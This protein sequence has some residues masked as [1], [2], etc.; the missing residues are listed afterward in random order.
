MLFYLNIISTLLALNLVSLNANEISVAQEIL[1]GIERASTPLRSTTLADVSSLPAL[2][3]DYLHDL[4]DALRKVNT[5]ATN[6]QECMIFGLAY[7]YAL[8]LLPERSPNLD[9]WNALTLGPNCGAM[10][11]P[12]AEA[13]GIPSPWP[14]SSHSFSQTAGP[15]FYVSPS[16]ADSNDGS[17]AFPF[18]TISHAVDTSRSARAPGSGPVTI[19]LRGGVHILSDTISLDTRDQYLSILNYPGEA[20]WVSGG[21]ALANLIWNPVNVTAG[22]AN[23][24]SAHVS[25]PPTYVTSLN[26]VAADGSPSKRLY[27]AQYPNFNPEWHSTGA[28]DPTR[29]RE[30]LERFNSSPVLQTHFQRQQ[31]IEKRAENVR[32]DLPIFPEIVSI[33]YKDPGILLWEKPNRF[34]TPQ[35]FFHDLKGL[36]LK[37]NSAMDNYNLY[38]AGR[39]GACGLWTNAWSEDSSYGWDYHCGNVT[40]G[41]WEEVDELMNSFGIL[42]IPVG[43]V[44]DSNILPNFKNWN[45]NLDPT[46]RVNG[47]A[48]LNVWMT[49]GWFN[50]FFYVTNHSVVNSSAGELSFLA[51]DKIYPLGGWQGGRHWQTQ[52]SFTTGGHD[53]PLL[54]NFIS[55]SN[56][57]EELDTYD[58]YFYDVMTQTLYVFY[59]ASDTENGN[60]QA[61]PPTGLV[62]MAPQLEVFFNL[63]SG[64]SDI[65]ISGLGFRDQRVSVLDNWVVPSGGDW[66]LRPFGLINLKDT[67]RITISNS[68]FK[69]TD[70]NAVFLGGRNRNATILNS[71][72]VWLGMN[73]VASLGET[74][75]DDAT[76]GEQPWGT[77]LSG[78]V[79]HELAL[80]EKQ[81]SAYFLGRTPLSRVENCLF[82]NGPRA[83]ININDHL[84]GGNNFT[85][86]LLFNSCRESGKSFDFFLTLFFLLEFSLTFSSS[87]SLS[88][89]DRRP[90]SY[91]QLA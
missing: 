45:L 37:N 67:D 9:V 76:G 20:A 26:T 68:L 35:T 1:H 49:Q 77:V 71:E 90:R 36:G 38:S 88:F 4:H 61:P 27:R 31:K 50:N 3:Q 15:M 12:T 10:P 14:P 28:C 23:I 74:V 58:E 65:T 11:P 70:S 5:S 66:G 79:A 69:R 84:G 43:M 72:C 56:V 91:E 29:S 41:G 22:G 25:S 46:Q 47:A 19:I 64:A 24:Y 59:N 30:C 63:S 55:V 16:G 7:E 52:D 33:D 60:P 39:G 48:V 82:Y 21:S 80:I 42:N 87:S 89:L 6:Q 54:G 18:A 44:Y 78:I 34:P 86:S 13:L 73:C 53:G 17:E 57:F 2:L 83:M 32:K 8:R 51:D 62:L 81:S 40:D 85:S 75:Q